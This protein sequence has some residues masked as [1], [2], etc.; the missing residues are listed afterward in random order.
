[1]KEQ[2]TEEKTIEFKFPK[3]NK[4]LIQQCIQDMSIH[5]WVLR[6]KKDEAELTIIMFQKKAEAK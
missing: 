5:D 6:K 4:H 3:E 1:M 2:K